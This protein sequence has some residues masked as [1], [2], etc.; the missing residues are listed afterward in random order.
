MVDRFITFEG[1]DG[2]G[3]SSALKA[4]IAALTERGWQQGQ[5]FIVTR[6]PGGDEVA[7]RI[8][9]LLLE[10]TTTPMDAVTEAYLYA[11]ARRQHVAN[12]I[13][14]ALAAG[15]LVLCDRFLD[16]SLTYQGAGRKLGIATVRQINALAVGNTLPQATVWFDVDPKVGLQRIFTQRQDEVNRMDQQALSFY[17]TIH[18][19]YRQLAEQEPQRYRVIDA[20]QSLASVK[21]QTLAVL[22][23]VVP[24]YFA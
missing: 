9:K 1:T 16:S 11:A 15:K 19:A 17:Q 24:Q 18:Q 7:E 21:N 6:E 2:S 13:K 10:P 5:D 23:Q 14:P 20:N 8:R 3:K 12:V 22:K 4:V